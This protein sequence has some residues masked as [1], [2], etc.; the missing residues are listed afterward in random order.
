[1]I[2]N[3]YIDDIVTEIKSGKLDLFEVILNYEKKID[4]IDSNLIEKI[5]EQEVEI[6]QLENEISDLE[7]TIDDLKSDIK[8]LKTKI[9]HQNYIIE[10]LQN[11]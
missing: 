8:E 6:Y 7:D 11:K 3:S 5:E 4:S 1:M 9:E 10:E 2:L